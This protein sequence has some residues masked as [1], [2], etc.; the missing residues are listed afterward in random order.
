MIDYN[1][2]NME[3]IIN[4]I[5][6]LSL[7]A[8]K[9]V[10]EL[11][12]HTP[13][14]FSRTF[15]TMSGKEVYMKYENLQK[16]GSFKIRG[17]AFKIFSIKDSYSGV[18]A[19]SA[20]NHAQG[21][22]YS[23]TK[24]GL[25][26]IIV[27]PV[28]APISKV[29]ATKNYGGKVILHGR[30][31]DEAE[32]KAKEIALEKNYAFIH[33]FDDPYIIA[34]QATLAHEII[35]DL[36]DIDTMVVPV[37]G[38]GLIS[39]IAVVFKKLS[40]E[41]RII[42]V[43]PESAPKFTVSLR[44]GKP[45]TVDVKPTIA[46]GLATKKP[47]KLTFNIVRK[48]V[49][50]M[51]TVNE[52]ELAKAVFLL[53]ERGKI[54]AEGAGAAGIAALISGKIEGKGRTVTIISGGNINLPLAYRVILRGLASEGR[55]ASISGTVP[56][57]PGVLNAITAI[58]ARHRAN[59]IEVIHDRADLRAPAWHASLKI[60]LETPSREELSKILEDLSRN[61]YNFTP[62]Y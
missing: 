29:E 37:G 6:S 21:V 45:V 43:E 60:I 42:G 36:E 44:R 57:Q 34:G 3:E 23:A 25:K 18:V 2:K 7:E 4:R 59:I 12:H 15:S 46:D 9:I 50:K 33:P 11:A 38:G 22:A 1:E 10:G 39:G 47:G 41:T 19:A 56:D 16:T 49:D 8:R 32:S 55:I 5:Y 62:L 28:T 31:Y 24:L 35:A 13:L 30:V 52:E 54:V 27:M 58:I 53:M 51:V 48:L 20:G 40:P 26:S 14:D 17:A 61:G